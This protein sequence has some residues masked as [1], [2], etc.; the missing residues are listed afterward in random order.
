M[1][2]QS[3]GFSSSHVWMTLD[4]KEGWTLKNWCLQTVVLEKTLESPLDSKEIKSVNPKR[5]QP[6]SLERLL[7]K[8]KFQYFGHLIQRVDS[9]EKTLMLGKTEGKRKRVRQRVRWLNN[10]TDSMDMN[11][12]KLQEIVEDRGAWQ[13]AVHEVARSWTQLID[14]TQQ[15]QIWKFPG[16]SV[17]RVLPFLSLQEAQV[18]SLVWELRSYKLHGP[19]KKAKQN[20]INKNPSKLNRYM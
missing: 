2:S 9:L 6:C 1:V 14:W 4:H 8:L 18:W 7:L 3:Y 17:V 12:S 10:T 19:A 5:N 15:Q 16:G 13:A 20:K 11:L